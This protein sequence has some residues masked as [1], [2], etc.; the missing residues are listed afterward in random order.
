MT[1]APHTPF[2]DLRETDARDQPVASTPAITKAAAIQHERGSQNTPHVVASGKGAI[3]EQILSIAF[4]RGIKVRSDAELVEM[5]TLIEVDSPIP[6][7]AFAAVAEILAY[8]Y[9]ANDARKP[10]A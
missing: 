9:Q 5:L 4:E 7:E 3:A 1:D 6:L 2:I 10:R 8:V